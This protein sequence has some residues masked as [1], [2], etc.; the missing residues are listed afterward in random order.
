MKYPNEYFI[1][2][3]KIN[4]KSFNICFIKSERVL[5]KFFLQFTTHFNFI[6]AG[7]NYICSYRV[8]IDLNKVICSL[9]DL[10]K[11]FV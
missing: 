2:P 9:I 4:L 1:H 3:L 11:R 5:F 8:L 10:I 7:L 6:N